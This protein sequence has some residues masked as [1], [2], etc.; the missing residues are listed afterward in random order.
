MTKLTDIQL[1]LLS[2]AASRPD[3]SLLP[4]PESLGASALRIRKGIAAL[5]KSGLAEEIASNADTES[6][7]EEGGQGIAVIIT[8]AGR[9]AIAPDG[10][11]STQPTEN[12]TAIVEPQPSPPAYPTKT[13]M[14]IDLLSR[15]EGATLADLLTATGWLPHTTRAALTGLRKKGRTITKIKRG[16]ETCYH[17][18]AA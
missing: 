3:G 5:I 9:A 16:S 17:V 6:W 13:A 15:S 2:T 14:V 8:H 10:N 12:I 11:G 18:A 1:I 4:P 7:R